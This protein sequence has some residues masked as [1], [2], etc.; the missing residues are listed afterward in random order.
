MK[1]ID[2][3]QDRYEE[4]LEIDKQVFD[5]NVAL[6]SEEIAFLSDPNYGKVI[7]TVDDN[8]N[9]F[10]YAFLQTGNSDTYKSPF[11]KKLESG[12]VYLHTIG[13]KQEFQGM[14]IGVLLTKAITNFVRKNGYKTLTSKVHPDNLASLRLL[15]KYLE[16]GANSLNTNTYGLGVDRLE[17]SS[18]SYRLP[19]E[20]LIE[21]LQLSGSELE[22]ETEL[23]ILLLP[24][25]QSE[26]LADKSANHSKLIDIFNNNYLFQGVLYAQ[27]C[28]KD[29]TCLSFVRAR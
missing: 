16:L 8:N 17:L 14:S 3:N 6:P 7:L 27:E 12:E 25:E 4:L 26:I 19:Y 20:K 5:S 23:E 28:K 29:T 1:I 11:V 24:V 2:L 15:T 10:G 22:R 21:Q 9:I 18:E 13:V